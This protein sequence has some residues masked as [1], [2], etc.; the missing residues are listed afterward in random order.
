MEYATQDWRNAKAK[1]T[2]AHGKSL[3]RST[4]LPGTVSYK[5]W[6]SY[7][8]YEISDFLYFYVGRVAIQLWLKAW[9]VASMLR[10]I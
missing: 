2:T 6:D 1:D 8:I 4:T 3:A 5:E 10:S 9:D 7:V